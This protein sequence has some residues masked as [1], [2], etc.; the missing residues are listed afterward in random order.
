MKVLIYGA[1]ALG[2]LAG[3]LLHDRAEVE[4]LGRDP[5]MAAV[6]AG[7]LRVSGL[8][9]RH[10]PLTARTDP[11]E[12]L[13]RQPE[14][15]ILSVKAWDTVQAVTELRRHW[16]PGGT[17]LSL[18]NGLGN[19]DAVSALGA[20][21]WN[22][23]GGTTGMGA[24]LAGPGEVVYA[25]GGATRLGAWRRAGALGEADAGGQGGADPGGEGA[26]DGGR[27]GRGARTTG[28]G[29][30]L[31]DVVALLSSSGF[32]VSAVDDLEAELWAKLIVNASINPLMA[33]TGHR[34]GYLLREG[35]ILEVSRAVCL[36][37]A[38]VAHARGMGMDPD[39][40]WARVKEVITRTAE[41]KCSMLQDVERGRQTEVDSITGEIVKIG[42]ERGVETPV[43]A[44]LWALMKGLEPGSHL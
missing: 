35:S 26:G 20:P 36:E 6:T 33:V 43:N 25:G 37:A 4:L 39:A 1:G 42:K 30:G 44:A 5:H 3:A 24:Y 14:L 18:Q 41:N 19:L 8:V 11:G 12:A 27:G 13:V 29:P 23:L 22:I 32:E 16:S 17:I 38:A 10:L 34:N 2:S 28:G 7:G 40:M 21:E 15:V 31:D 9:D